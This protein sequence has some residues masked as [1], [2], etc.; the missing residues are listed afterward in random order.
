[1]QNQEDMQGMY[2]VE[3][4]IN[5]LFDQIDTGQEFAV[6]GNSP[7][8]DWQLVDMVVANIMALQEYTHSYHMWKS[9][10]ADDRTWLQFKEQSQ[11]AYLDIEELEQTAST[12]GYGGANNT[13][14]G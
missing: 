12:S 3:D 4:P 9:I 5:I 7:F 6:E 10:A 14:H 1:M 11:K 2:N 8:S 13:K